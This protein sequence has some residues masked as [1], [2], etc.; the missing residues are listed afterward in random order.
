MKRTLGL[1]ML[2]A[3]TAAFAG[4]SQARTTISSS[5]PRSGTLHV[6]KECSQYA[7]TPGSFCTI[8]SSSLGRIRVGSKVFYA[9]AAG[10]SVL[11]SDI[12]LYAGPGN[13]AIGHVTLDFATGTGPLT[14]VGGTGAFKGFHAHLAVSYDAATGLW[15][16]DG[17]YRFVTR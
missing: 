5:A 16:W 4:A 2:I 1:I 12:F 9:E 13:T 11:D 10:A 7:G 8:T 3:C 6:T 15:H 14:I 17:P